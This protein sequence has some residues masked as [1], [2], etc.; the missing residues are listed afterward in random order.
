MKFLLFLSLLLLFIPDVRANSVWNQKESLPVVGRHRGTGLAIGDKGYLGLGHINGTGVNIVFSDWWEFDPATNSWTQKADYPVGNYGALAFS[1]QNKGYVGGGV[2]LNDE[3]YEYNPITNQ[4]T[5]IPDAPFSPSDRT[6]FGLNDKGYITNGNGL[7]EYDPATETW[8]IKQS[9]PASF[10]AWCTSFVIGS[11]AYVKSGGNV[12]EYKASQD[13]W[14][15]K[16]PFPGLTSNGASAFAINGKGYV[17]TGYGFGLSD[18][19]REFWEFDPASN[20]WTQQPD[21]PGTSR[22]FSVA[23]AINNRGYFGG[24]TNGTNFN[25]FWEYNRILGVDESLKDGAVSV[26]TYPNPATE[27]VNFVV[28]ADESDPLELE[29]YN[30]SG[31]LIKSVRLSHSDQYLF[32]RQNLSKG[33]YHYRLVQNQQKIATGT[34]IF[35]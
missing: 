29:I 10:S 32:E 25:D 26:S 14:L 11:S 22:R 19:N 20:T 31:Q 2:F 13:T 3:F 16:A 5:A 18:V 1:T 34:I 6:A 28:N 15:N 27:L 8:A 21:F 30:T 33:Y 4:W 9:P 23:F 24:G 35:N 17:V 7:A 12:Y